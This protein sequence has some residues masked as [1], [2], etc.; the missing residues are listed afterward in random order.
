MG[1]ST[2]LQPLKVCV[3]NTKYNLEETFPD[4]LLSIRSLKVLF[5]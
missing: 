3:I 2:H 4:T 1:V 5:E